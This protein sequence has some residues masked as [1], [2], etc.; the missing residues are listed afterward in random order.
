MEKSIYQ[1]LTIDRWKSLNHMEYKL[2]SLRQVHGRLALKF[3]NWV[4]QQPGLKLYHLTHLYSITAHVLVRARMHGSAK[5]IL[6][7][8]SCMSTCTTSV[9]AAVMNTYP[10]CK[11]N[12]SVFDLLIKIYLREGNVGAALETFYLM[13]SRGF[14][15]ST[16]TCNMVL[17]SM[18]K[19]SRVGSAWLFFQRML[20]RRICPDV[21]TFNI[22]LHLLGGQG[23][24]KKAI[25]LLRKMEASGYDPNIVTYNTMVNWCC[26]KGRYK[27]A[28]EL[29]DQMASKGIPADVF[30][31]NM[32][33]DDL[34]RTSKSTKGYLLLR[35]MRNRKIP[36]N[37]VTYNTLINGFVKEGKVDVATQIFDEMSVFGLSPDSRSYNSLID[38]HCNL[39]N[40]EEAFRLL[41]MLEAS[42]LRPSEVSYGTLLKG[43][44]R[45][46]KLH[47]ARSLLGRMRINKMAGCIAYTTMIDGLCQNG[48][49]DEAVQ[50]LNGM[51]KE[52][53]DPDIITFSVLINGFCRVGKFKCAKE[54]A[55][56][57]YRVGIKPNNVVYATLVYHYCRTGNITQAFR[58][59]AA[60]NYDGHNAN[61]FV[62]NIL[63]SS[64]SR[65]GMLQE[66]K[67]FMHHMSRVGIAPNSITFNSLINGFAKLGD[68][69]VS[70]SL[71]DEMLHSGHHP[72]SFTYSSLLMGVCKVGN[73]REARTFLDT[74]H[75]IPYAV[76]T[77]TY[78]TIIAE[79]CRLGNL[80]DALS[81]L[82]AMVHHNVLPDE[83]TYTIILTGLIRKG[84]MT[85]A[86]LF[87]GKM[88]AKGIMSPNQAIYT[89]LIDGLFKAGQ[90]KVALY[91]CEEMEKKC[92]DIDIIATNAIIDGCSRMG[93]TT[94]VD[95]LFTRLLTSS[96]SPSLAT[97]NIVLHGY[98]RHNDIVKCSYIYKIMRS[99]DVLPDKLTCHS[100]LLGL[101]KAGML[102][103]G[104]KMLKK[105]IMVDSDLVDRYMFNMVISL[106]CEMDKLP[107][108]F[109][110][111]DTMK[112]AGVSPDVNTVNST[113][114]GLIRAHALHESHLLFLELL[115]N[116]IVPKCTQYIA[117]IKKMCRRGEIHRAFRLK[118]EM[119]AFH[120]SSQDVAESAMV[121]GLAKSGKVEDA[122]MVLDYMLRRKL[123]PT[124]ATFTTLMHMLVK[125]DSIADVIKLRSKMELCGVK[126][127][128]VVYNVLMTGLC[129]NDDIAGAFKLFEEMKQRGLLPNMTTYSIM[130]KA[131]MRNETD[132]VNSEMLLRDLQDRGM[133]YV[134]QVFIT[135][136]FLSLRPGAGN[137]VSGILRKLLLLKENDSLHL[138]GV[139]GEELDVIEK[140]YHQA[141]KLETEFFDAQPF[142]L[143]TVVP[144]TKDHN[145]DKD[146]LVIFSDFD[147]PCTVVDSSAV[148]AEIAIVTAPK[149][150]QLQP[151][152]QIHRKSSAELRNTWGLLSTQLWKSM[153]SA[154]KAYCLLEKIVKAWVKQLT[155]QRGYTDQMVEE[156][157]A[158]IFTFGSYRLG[159]HNHLKK[160][161][162]GY[163]LT[164][165]G[166]TCTSTLVMNCG[167]LKL[168]RLYLP[169]LSRFS[170]EV[171]SSMRGI[172]GYL[173]DLASG[174][175]SNALVIVEVLRGAMF[176]VFGVKVTR[177]LGWIDLILFSRI[178]IRSLTEN[179]AA[180]T[181]ASIG[182]ASE[183]VEPRVS[184]YRLAA[185]L[186]SAFAIYT[187][188]FWT[189]LSVVMPEPP[190]E[191]VSWVRGAA[192]VKRLALPV[193]LIV[194]IT[195]IS[196]A[197][198][199]GND[200]GRAYN[201]FP[202]MG[203]TWIPDSI[204]EM[205]PLIRNFFENTATVQ[206]VKHSLLGFHVARPSHSCDNNISF[207]CGN[208]VVHKKD[209]HP[210]VRSLIG[211][212][213]GMAVLQVSLGISTLLSYVP[214]SLGTAHQARGFN[215]CN[216]YDAAESHGSEAFFAPSQVT[217]SSCKATILMFTC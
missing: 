107:I 196:G 213:V 54:V 111:L 108:A 41:K 214:V 162:I 5:L 60:M 192:K 100:L 3:L 215:T 95:K 25:H 151:E 13:G 148:L 106:C 92:P 175:F 102:D 123:V 144:L 155:R 169:V 186:T 7:Q 136:G 2:S 147:L 37:E 216:N 201:T 141:M 19:D 93:K 212:T 81:L 205:K 128:V 146:R 149:S 167:R 157:N 29:I 47:L 14:N 50:L 134:H 21:S 190:A 30:T 89:C 56:R 67:E 200:A 161:V 129:E 51:V 78:N 138:P 20:A 139:E 174:S 171:C 150:D 42:G 154:L 44:C 145:P 137:L 130:I 32:L 184:P 208:V 122:M 12:P 66:A 57:M 72:C 28:F 204:F 35:N 64:L 117:L 118:D 165:M 116:G 109:D 10:L 181:V 152:N 84:K 202:K 127:D 206:A 166:A 97:Y 63:A 105:M 80:S 209:L 65:S 70:F 43:L 26:K 74:L 203:E 119:V 187:S 182:I 211:S 133:D 207:N 158:V 34:C 23:K 24:I 121:R 104:V 153:S 40:F 168:S 86:L 1:L 189:A 52:G 195:A 45:H 58:V 11:S 164:R 170:F 197:F 125:K 16:H 27:I 113:I 124:I 49:M 98:A 8:L 191:S 178:T 77:V 61:P 39:A 94:E 90:S 188:L 48:L 53:A 163:Q 96:F 22:L 160:R 114:S 103:V 17:S 38:G 55:C 217:A 6:K 120:V 135:S 4:M 36:P 142:L 115:E 18:V 91:F 159:Y 131:M 173:V 73:L 46:D 87:Y 68:A 112:V 185:Y 83:Y 126:L 172:G 180:D 85:T 183:Y 62:C 9:F 15:A 177:C 176:F 198:V 110:L 179:F 76:D 69:I 82:N 210:A 31:Y 99:R 59:Y 140:L 88:L 143:P 132:L 33:I 101:C 71:F 75:Q 193:S 79:A 199:A 156:A 194:G